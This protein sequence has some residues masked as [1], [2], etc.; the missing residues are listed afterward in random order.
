MCNKLMLK[1]QL[2][3]LRMQEGEDVVGH[4]QQFDRMSIDLLNI[5]V[6]LEEEDKSL[7]LLCSL[8]R[9]FDPLVTTLL[10]DKETL[11]YEKIVSMLRSNKQ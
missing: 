4:I 3:S 11:V 5:G 6:D 2:Y 8:Q 10:Y 1:K 7:L 9:I